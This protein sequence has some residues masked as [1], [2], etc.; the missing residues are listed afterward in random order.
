MHFCDS[1]HLH[2]PD[3]VCGR[4]RERVRA[5]EKKLEKTG[6]NEVVLLVSFT[7]FAKGRHNV[8]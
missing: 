4:E 6:M 3:T 8:L 2:E 7:T 5:K 1:P